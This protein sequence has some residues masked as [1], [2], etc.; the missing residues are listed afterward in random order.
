[1]GSIIYG[2]DN[3]HITSCEVA[4]K[5]LKELDYP[6][7]RIEKIKHCIISHR[8]SQDINRETTEAKILAEADAMSHFDALPGL[9]R[10]CYVF[11]NVKSQK[12]A[13]NSVKRKLTNSY[14][15]LST[16]AREIIKPKFKAAMLL[17]E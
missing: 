8:G 1:M 4:E 11:E 6:Q 15:K 13:K 14:N 12:D 2:R 10:A 7:D 16:E 3:H 9:F 17:L 5:K